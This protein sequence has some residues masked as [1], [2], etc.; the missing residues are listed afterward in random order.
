MAAGITV[1]TIAGT[2]AFRLAI[3]KIL[4]LLQAGMTDQLNQDMAE[5]NTH[6]ATMVQKLFGGE[7]GAVA[8]PTEGISWSQRS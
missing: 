1:T 4:E 7:A 8:D 5:L 2:V 3:P 6:A